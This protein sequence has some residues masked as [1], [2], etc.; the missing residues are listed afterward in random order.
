MS[1]LPPPTPL[2]Y[3]CSI[4]YLDFTRRDN[5]LRHMRRIHSD[6]DIDNIHN[7][8]VNIHNNIGNI[9]NNT[10][11]IHN[12]TGNVPN[13]NGNEID[14]QNDKEYRCKKCDKCLYAK[15][16]LT[17]HMEK[18]KGIRDKYSCE[19]CHKTFTHDTSRF[20]HY[21]ICKTKKEIDSKSLVPVTDTPTAISQQVA[22]TINNV[23]GDQNNNNTQ[24]NIVNILTFP[25]SGDKNF[26]FVCDQITKATMKALLNASS[27][28]FIGFNKFIGTV[29][30]NPQNRIVHKTNPNSTYSKIHVGDGKWEFAHDDDVFPVITHHMTTAALSKVNEMKDD[31]KLVKELYLKLEPFRNH[32]TD[33]NEMEYES[34]E[35]KN[36]LQR[37]K[38][39]LVNLTRKWMEEEK[40]S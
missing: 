11:N 22:S 16:Y 25:Q 26:D 14:I 21:K 7:N 40:M 36:I 17:K 6:I 24:N 38:L 31:M 4:C 33:V 12:N 34:S 32:I 37:I 18:C 19:Y 28:P 3:T 1:S 35:Y 5:M 2:N 13:N 29:M 23:S 10:G 39:I 8:T 27:T 20:K 9:H 15:W 30:E